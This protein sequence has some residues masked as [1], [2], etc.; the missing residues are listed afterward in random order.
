MLFLFPN[1]SAIPYNIICNYRL[2]PI[3]YLVS[4]TQYATAEL[5]DRQLPALQEAANTLRSRPAKGWI[6]A[7]RRALGISSPALAKLLKVSQ[8]TILEYERGEVR[9]SITLETLGRVADALDAELIVALVP[10]KSVAAAL[11]ARAESIAREEMSA[12]INTMRLE[13]QEVETAATREEYEKLVA[14]L[15][16][17]P[18]KLWR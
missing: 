7:I 13:D 18:R 14:S 5:L 16:A 3:G 11:R 2:Y 1:T 6:A 10:R 12:V 17:N 9:G 4:N 15:L 8:P